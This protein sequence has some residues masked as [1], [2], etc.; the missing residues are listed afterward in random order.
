M[1]SLSDPRFDRAVIYVCV[2][3]EQGAMGLVVNNAMA[4]M[5]FK[6]L[7]DQLGIASDIELK[8][9]PENLTV[10]NGGPVENARGFLLHSN[11]FL[12]KDT[13]KIDENF[14][15]TGTID[16]LKQVANGEGPDQM[17]FMLGYAGWGAKQL[18]QELAQNSWLVVDPDPEIIFGAEHDKKWTKSVSK[19]GF[20]PGMLS[21]EAGRA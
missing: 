4:G 10:M 8:I 6:N 13:I 3:D 7:L 18:E 16:A 20:D 15:V 11:D 9:A 14:S 5:E 12:Q 19:L 2:H 21:G 1:P 17:L